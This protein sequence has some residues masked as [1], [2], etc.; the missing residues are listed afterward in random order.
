M[1]RQGAPLGFGRVLLS[2]LG[3][4]A[5]TLVFVFWLESGHYPEP[6]PTKEP[7]PVDSRL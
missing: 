3:S 1:A 6:G 7:L 2:R 4:G 5:G